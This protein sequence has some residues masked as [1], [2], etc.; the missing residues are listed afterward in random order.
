MRR[1]AADGV[2][3]VARLVP[4]VRAAAADAQQFRGAL[5]RAREVPGLLLRRRLQPVRRLAQAVL[6]GLLPVLPAREAV[7]VVAASGAVEL[8]PLHLEVVATGPPGTAMAV[9]L[10]GG[11]AV[12]VAVPEGL[13]AGATFAVAV[14]VTEQPVAAAPP[15]A[16]ARRRARGRGAAAVR[17]AAG[18]ARALEAA[19]G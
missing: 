8:A 11:G 12:Q 10:P 18:T 17:P 3:R 15:P 4:V 9:P 2:L 6:Q 16:A 5:P 14:P 7:P 19:A 13:A 1:A